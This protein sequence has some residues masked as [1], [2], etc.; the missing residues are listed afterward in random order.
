VPGTPT[1]N[2]GGLAQISAVSCPATGNCSTAGFYDGA[3]GTRPFVV[4][5][6]NGTWGDAVALGGAPRNTSS[7]VNS[8]SCVS[9]GNCVAAGDDQEFESGDEFLPGEAFAVSE[10]NGH[11]GDPVANTAWK[12]RQINS[13]SCTK[14]V[15]QCGAGGFSTDDSGHEQTFV[16]D[17]T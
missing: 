12:L 16:V 2:T 17:R 3:K 11:W 10:V 1:L 15:T 4:S 8:I 14:V 5:Q 9:A 13:V 6:D 7:E